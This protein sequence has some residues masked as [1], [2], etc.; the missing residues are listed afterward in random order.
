MSLPVA[1]LLASSSMSVI[2]EN[3]IVA[4][5][6][7]GQNAGAYLAIANIGDREDRLIET[8]CECAERVEIHR[9]RRG[10]GGAGMTVEPALAIAP[11]GLA[12]VRPGSE[13]HLM[14][15]GLRAPLAAGQSVDVNLRFERAGPMNAPFTVVADS[16]AGWAAQLPRAMHPTFQALSFLAGSCWRATFPDGRQT[17]THCFSPIYGGRFMHDRHVVEGAPTP[18][19]GETLYRLQPMERRVAFDYRASDGGHSIGT[20]LPAPNGVAFPAQ[21]HRGQDGAEMTI[22]S[23][24]TRDGDNAYVALSERRQ[25]RRWREM[26]RMRFERIGPATAN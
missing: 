20:A 16:G 10:A 22:R 2:V 8:S 12:E 15:I 3:R 19:S 17:D 6:P 24:W 9:V 1:L 21:S 26:W 11:A 13:V 25:G 5:A 4:A 18:Y 14:L 7:A 23:S